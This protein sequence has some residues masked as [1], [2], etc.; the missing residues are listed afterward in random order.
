[1]QTQKIA[2]K[3]AFCEIDW[4]LAFFCGHSYKFDVLLYYMQLRSK[5]DLMCSVG[6]IFSCCVLKVFICIKNY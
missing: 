1:M 5:P 3:L 2:K 4:V 6:S